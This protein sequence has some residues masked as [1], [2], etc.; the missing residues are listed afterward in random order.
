MSPAPEG[1]PID[2]AAI[3][4][5]PV[6]DLW[7][8]LFAARLARERLD[9]DR[10][11][12]VIT[13][14]L[15]AMPLVESQASL[16]W[17]HAAPIRY[18]DFH[19]VAYGLPARRLRIDALRQPADAAVLAQRASLCLVAVP[20]D[21]G[22]ALG[23]LPVMRAAVDAGV[24][25][26][27]FGASVN[28]GWAPLTELAG[29]GGLQALM[30]G[31]VLVLASSELTTVLGAGGLRDAE[32][33]VALARQL[34][35]SHQADLTA[36]ALPEGR[37]RV[38]LRM[39][40]IY[41]AATAA[42]P[43]AAH[44]SNEGRAMFNHRGMGALLLP[45]GGPCAA[46]LLLRNVRARVDDTLV[47]CGHRILAPATVDYTEHGA[48]MKLVLTAP[49]TPGPGRDAVLHMSLARA[50]VPADSFC[51]IGAAEFTV[52]TA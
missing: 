19:A 21:R 2:A 43:L 4:P 5:L 24:P 34:S 31:D 11:V 28:A 41:L 38:R 45:W 7:V 36:L 6:V 1:L 17:I 32:G 49:E 35:V 9:R 27:L 20:A 8:D 23:V 40:P 26:V 47:A 12:A 37:L 29:V 51:D 22:A 14:A 50:A 48:I 42:E 52:E 46:R 3:A 18:R 13:D 15:R 25:L 39:D 33:A 10:P 44:M 30:T 16:G